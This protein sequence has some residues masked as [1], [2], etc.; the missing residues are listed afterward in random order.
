MGTNIRP[1][2]TKSNDYWISRHRYYE[3]KHF[4]MQYKEWREEYAELDSCIAYG[5]VSKVHTGNKVSIPV[6]Q[7]MERRL[8]LSDRINLVERL[9]AEAGTDLKSYLLKAVT[10]GLSYDVLKA[11][12]DIPCCRSVYYDIYRKFFWLL[13]KE[14]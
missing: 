8:Y 5:S 2:I 11:K 4:C 9:S 13:S 10:E 3:L 14:R 1:E 6:E 12:L 7:V